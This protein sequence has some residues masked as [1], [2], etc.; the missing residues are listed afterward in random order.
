M[1]Y[2]NPPIEQVSNQPRCL[3][4][5]ISEPHQALGLVNID[6]KIFAIDGGT[7]PEMQ[8]KFFVL[9]EAI[10]YEICNS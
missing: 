5:L 9:C 1:V 6:N 7:D 3:E 4:L 2:Q 10:K 8:V